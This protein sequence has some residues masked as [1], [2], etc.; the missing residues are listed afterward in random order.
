M[1]LG[2][3]RQEMRDQGVAVDRG[4]VRTGAVKG[5]VMVEGGSAGLDLDRHEPKLL[6]VRGG[7][8]DRSEPIRGRVKLSAVLGGA[9]P[10]M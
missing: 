9:G 3:R 8:L 7:A 6:A 4:C 1:E 10:A 5:E 2:I